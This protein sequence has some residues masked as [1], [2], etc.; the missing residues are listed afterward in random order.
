MTTASLAA[1]VDIALRIAASELPA[2]EPPAPEPP[3]PDSTEATVLR[4]ADRL[5]REWYSAPAGP[6]C[7]TLPATCP[8]LAGLLRTAH[9]GSRVW[10]SGWR[11]RSAVG[12]SV[13]VAEREPHTGARVERRVVARGD[14]VSGDHTSAGLVPSAD[15]ALRVCVRQDL[16]AEGWWCTWGGGWSMTPTAAGN[17]SAAGTQ[18]PLLRLYLA[19]FVDA[20]A[21]VVAAVTRVT[22]TWHHP[23]M[24]KA[25]TDPETYR[26]ADPVVLYLPRGQSFAAA[27][28]LRPVLA[29]LAASLRPVQ[30]PLSLL[31]GRGAAVAE[32]PL[33]EQS[34]GEHRC[35]AIAR[36]VV[37]H[38][39]DPHRAVGTALRGLGVDPFAPYRA[40]PDAAADD[41]GADSPSL[42]EEDVPWDTWW[43]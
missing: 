39:G 22:L 43:S 24:L 42:V 41:V 16:L 11:T 1:G 40:D 27:R 33:G 8:P 9:A 18:E 5:Y 10:Q 3:T 13:L 12:G 29:G 25:G 31:V 36:A 6:D 23:W 7:G 14:W 19:P 30:P 2:P 17:H 4:V 38:T 15:D 37:D 26:R 28:D 20:V 35:T 32:D 34:F 21:D